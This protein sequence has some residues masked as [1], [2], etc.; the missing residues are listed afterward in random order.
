M[1]LTDIV[2][3]GGIRCLLDL[4]PDLLIV[5]LIVAGVGDTQAALD[6]LNESPVVQASVILHEAG[7]CFQLVQLRNVF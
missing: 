3:L 1:P 4:I 6:F 5:Q 7:H 2:L